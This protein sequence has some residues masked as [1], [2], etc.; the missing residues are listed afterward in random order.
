MKATRVEKMHMLLSCVATSPGP[1]NSMHGIPY[2][3]HIACF[4]AHV[5]PHIF[6]LS[7]EFEGHQWGL[8]KKVP[9]GIMGSAVNVILLAAPSSPVLGATIAG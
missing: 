4:S 1:A 9:M 7:C 6:W 5:W 2:G 3:S 8:P